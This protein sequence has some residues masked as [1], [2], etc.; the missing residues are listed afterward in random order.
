MSLQC[1][2][3]TVRNESTVGKSISSAKIVRVIINT[4]KRLFDDGDGIIL[5][6][7]NMLES[8]GILHILLADPSTE[9]VRLMAD[10][11]RAYPDSGARVAPNRLQQIKDEHLAVVKSVS[12]L[13]ERFP[14]CVFAKK[15]GN[16][17]F[18]S[19]I[20]MWGDVESNRDKEFAAVGKMGGCRLTP[21]I[22]PIWSIDMPSILATTD[23]N[24]SD[25]DLLKKCQ[26][27]FDFIWR[28][29]STSAID[30]QQASN[31]RKKLYTS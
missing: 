12:R 3:D 13:H 28:H 15:F 16:N 30:L 4:G 18:R 25:N 19:T 20:I 11:E 17:M 26:C 2:T 23:P 14:D 1:T 31:L 22:Q 27:H 9:H 24:E 21:T 29:P 10:A 5:S 7:R 6:L 8:G